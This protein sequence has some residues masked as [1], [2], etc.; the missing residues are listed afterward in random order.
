MSYKENN[1]IL[2]KALLSLNNKLEEN[3]IE[4]LDLKV[5]GGYAMYR[6]TD[7]MT[8]DI[9]NTNILTNEIKNLILEV[10]EDLSNDSIEEDWLNDDWGVFQSKSYQSRL[11]D[12]NIKW[13]TYPDIV[14]SKITVTFAQLSSLMCMKYFAMVER[15]KQKD[16][17]DFYKLMKNN[18]ISIN[19][20]LL[21]LKDH[22]IEDIDDVI[23]N[24][25]IN[26]IITEK[27]Y[28]NFE[29]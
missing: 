27:D 4:K 24:L 12:K 25:Y 13:E 6:F 22:E 1:D 20:F 18:N 3:N 5:C 14:L 2:F 17:N 16:R 9:Y 29:L 7:S 11:I 15:S 19:D 8:R 26:G 10:F 23:P 21:M 28:I